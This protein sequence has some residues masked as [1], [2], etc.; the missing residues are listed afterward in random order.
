MD[1]NIVKLEPGEECMCECH[2]DDIM[3][4]FG[5]PHT[6]CM[7]CTCM[8]CPICLHYVP[9]ALYTKHESKYHPNSRQ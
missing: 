7:E 5:T 3:G 4:C 6:G 9:L 8:R 1:K 2:K